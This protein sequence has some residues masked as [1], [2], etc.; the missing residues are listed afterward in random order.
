MT[1]GTTSV[2]A[3]SDANRAEQ[4]L[5]W[6]LSVFILSCGLLAHILVFYE[7]PRNKSYRKPMFKGFIPM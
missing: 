3:P 7:W 4:Q 5:Y 1:N 6:G 2:Y